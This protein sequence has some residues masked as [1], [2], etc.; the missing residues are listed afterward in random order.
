M[1]GN[2][3][4]EIRGLMDSGRYQG[5]HMHC[6]R[7]V[8]EHSWF[9]SKIAHGLAFWEKNKFGNEIDMEKVLFYP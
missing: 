9:V 6:R 1:F 8:A 2:H 5:R 3:L 4:E 7:S